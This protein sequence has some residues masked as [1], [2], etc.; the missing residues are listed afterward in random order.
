MQSVELYINGEA[1][2]LSDKTVISLVLQAQDIGDISE[3]VGSFSRSFTVPATANNRR[4]LEH[5]Y[6][7]DT[8]T[9]FPYSRHKAIIYV[10][11]IEIPNGTVIV[12]A[13]GIKQD[14]I[15]LTY[16]TGNSPFFQVIKDIKVRDIPYYEAC[17]NRYQE[18]IFSTSNMGNYTYG[19]PII[20]YSGYDS[21]VD[22]NGVNV[23]LNAILPAVYL[24]YVMN[25]ISDRLGYKFNLGQFL[26]EP[27]YRRAV[28]PFSDTKLLRC[29]YPKHRNTWKTRYTGTQ[30]ILQAVTTPSGSQ[31]QS[32]QYATFT[33]NQ[34]I[35][36]D[37]PFKRLTI[38]P[39]N[40]PVNNFINKWWVIDSMQYR[41]KKTFRFNVNISRPVKLYPY[42]NS[43]YGAVT[44]ITRELDPSGNGAVYIGGNTTQGFGLNDD[45]PIPPSIYGYETVVEYIDQSQAHTGVDVIKLYSQQDW[46]VTFVEVEVEWLKDIGTTEAQR[47]ITFDR[48]NNNSYLLSETIAMER[49]SK[50]YVSASSCLPDITVAEFLKAV[51]NLYGLIL[52]VDEDKKE[53]EFFPLKSLYDNIPKANDWSDRLVNENQTTINTRPKKYGQRNYFKFTENDLVGDTYGMYTLTINDNTLPLE[54]NIVKVP[55]SASDNLERLG[56]EEIGYIQRWT[57]PDLNP[58]YEGA[59]NKQRIMIIDDLRTQS[60]PVNFYYFNYNGVQVDKTSNTAKVAYYQRFNNM[61][62]TEPQMSF[63]AYLYERFYG[64]FNEITDRYK[65]INIYM[66]LSPTDIQTLDFRIP[67]Y[68]KQFNGYFYI[69][70]IS[71]WVDGK[72][73][74]KVELLKIR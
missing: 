27:A 66:K 56:G 71:D 54:Y 38:S 23:N 34:A 6:T 68:L 63:E 14:E 18:E 69:Q 47:L 19:Y 1:L 39:Y 49:P 55:F 15:R 35:D 31:P 5:T 16:Y 73:P 30:N 41:I 64:G 8:V 32:I 4:I 67:I 52:F 40:H 50:S 33:L 12:E 29:K 26:Y 7:Y 42:P 11:G 59:D 53:V 43:L 74:V 22:D 9:D 51:A 25:N 37:N 21:H 3:K 10:N 28:L 58:E 70:R 61:P 46:Q 48:S 13:D 36:V 20:C 57:T 60:Y 45:F 2:D 62:P 44:C 24:E 72:K 65:E 17:H